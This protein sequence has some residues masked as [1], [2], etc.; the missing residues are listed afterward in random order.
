MSKIIELAKQLEH[1]YSQEALYWLDK[2][3]PRLSYNRNQ[4][5]ELMFY[6]QEKEIDNLDKLKSLQKTLVETK[7]FIQSSSH[8]LD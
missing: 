6:I 5:E 1:R 8:T 7:K 2:R 4:L 3:K